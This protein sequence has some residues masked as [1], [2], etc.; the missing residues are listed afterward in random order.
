MTGVGVYALQDGGLFDSSS[1]VYYPDR[2]NKADFHEAHFDG[3]TL[4]YKK[5]DQAPASLVD[6]KK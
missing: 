5:A 3:K 6:Y 4:R 1:G 2:E